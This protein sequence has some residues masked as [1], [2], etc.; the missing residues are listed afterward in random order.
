ML[1]ITL[2]TDVVVERLVFETWSI[3]IPLHFAEEFVEDGSYWHAWDECRS[4]S[5]TSMLLTD[6]GQPVPAQLIVKDLRPPF[7]TPIDDLP[8]GL[9]GWGAI[10]PAI[11][12]A[13]ASRVLCGCL[14][15]DGRV[16]IVTITS[17]DLQWARG[18]WRSVRSWEPWPAFA[19]RATEARPN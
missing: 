5:L 18:V 6:Q 16:L 17:D 11:Q 15:V 7:G 1:P 2:D 9:L 14:A 4:V 10:G 19:L 3:E 8:D 13:P 12:P